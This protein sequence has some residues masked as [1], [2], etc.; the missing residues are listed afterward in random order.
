MK[1][2][3]V[4]LDWFRW[5]LS[6]QLSHSRSTKFCNSAAPCTSSGRLAGLGRRQ[7]RLQGLL[8]RGVLGRVVHRPGEGLPVVARVAWRNTQSWD[9]FPAFPAKTPEQGRGPLKMASPKNTPETNSARH[10]FGMAS[11]PKKNSI[12]GLNQQNLSH[13]SQKRVGGII[14][15]L[16]VKN[17]WVSPLNLTP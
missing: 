13:S 10:F 2:L 16:L 15:G 6:W 5:H 4:N 8:G 12:K 14:G 7:R 17:R 9:G 1:G 11:S 3:H